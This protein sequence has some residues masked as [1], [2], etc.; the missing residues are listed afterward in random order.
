MAR[1]DK[2]ILVICMGRIKNDIPTEATAEIQST[3]N[4][5]ILKIVCSITYGRHSDRSL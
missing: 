5:N 4:E 2:R 1:I 3:D